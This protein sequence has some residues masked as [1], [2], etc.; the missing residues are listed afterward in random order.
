MT[1][2][3]SRRKSTRSR[4]P[5][6]NPAVK[7]IIRWTVFERAGR[8][9]EGCGRPVRFDA[10]VLAPDAM[11]ASHRVGEVHGGQFTPENLCC[12]CRDCH[13][14]GPESPHAHPE[15]ARRR[16]LACLSTED[17]AEKPVQLWTGKWVFLTD[18]GK[19]REAA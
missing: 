18:D 16:G 14:Y 13:L 5:A 4:P 12:L 9:C 2:R 1:L 3:P 15:A 6:E 17:P 7:A 8:R 19:Y 11:H 10:P